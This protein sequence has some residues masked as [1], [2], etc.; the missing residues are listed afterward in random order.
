MSESSISEYEQAKLVLVLKYG[1]IPAAYKA[2]FLMTREEQWAM[3]TIQYELMMEYEFYKEN[4][5]PFI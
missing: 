2:F 1:S 3:D 4:G 5:V